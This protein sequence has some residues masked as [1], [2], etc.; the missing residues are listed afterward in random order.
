WASCN[1]SRGCPF[2]LSSEAGLLVTISFSGSDRMDNLLKDHRWPTFAFFA[3]VRIGR[4]SRHILFLG[5]TAKFKIVPSGLKRYYGAD[6]LHFVNCSCYH[7]QRWL[8]SPRRRDLFLQVLEQVRQ[9]YDFVV[10]GY[11]VMPEHIHL[12]ISEPAK[13]NP[14]RVMQALK[15]GFA[16]R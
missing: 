5:R 12:L 10:V 14:S 11:V 9:R 6:H 1:L 8:G 16:R 3:K 15:Q 13:G 2:G 4:V 7:R